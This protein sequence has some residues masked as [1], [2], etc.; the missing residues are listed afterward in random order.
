MTKKSVFIFL[1]ILC[2]IGLYAQSLTAKQVKDEA[3]SKTSA[4]ESLEYV[5]SKLAEIKDMTEKRAVYS[6]LGTLQEELSMYK[7]AAASYA[8]AA[9]IAGSDA[10]GMPKKSNQQLVIDAVRCSLN[11]G[12]WETADGYLN[13][14]VRN[15]KNSSIQAYIKLYEQWSALCRCEKL[16]ETEEAVAMLKAYLELPSMK[17]V[18]PSVIFT[19]WYLT[20]E[21]KYASMLNEEFPKSP[22]AGIVNGKLQLLPSPFW[23]FVPHKENAGVNFVSAAEETVQNTVAETVSEKPSVKITSVNEETAKAKKY[24]LGLFRKKDNAQSFSDTLKNAGFNAYVEEETRSSGTMYFLVIVDENADGNIA[25]KLR[26][27]GY[28]CYPVF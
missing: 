21:P 6:F 20:A 14:S 18:K 10:V 19:L 16:E 27:A 12:D 7:E 8:A 23:F 3:L 24:Q 1:L 17:D 4:Q 28:E 25:D 5:Q 9:G 26:T 2:G 13:S 22:E 11:S 15:S